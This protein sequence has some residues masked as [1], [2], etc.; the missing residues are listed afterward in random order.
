MCIAALCCRLVPPSPDACRSPHAWLPQVHVAFTVV[1]YRSERYGQRRGV[2]TSWLHALLA[3]LLEAPQ[4]PG[5]PEGAFR[6]PVFLRRGGAFGPPESL[7]TPLIM[8]GPG[9]G[10]APFRGFLQHRRAQAAAGEAAR[11]AAKGQAWLFFGCR[12]RDQDYLY[13]E[14]LQVSCIAVCGGGGVCEVD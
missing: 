6:L 9:T 1:R 13:K 2:A 14:D 8:V 12:H 11:S 3:P 7:D 10:V 5:G 4:G